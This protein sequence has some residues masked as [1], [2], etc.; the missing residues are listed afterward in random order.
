MTFYHR[1]STGLTKIAQ[2]KLRELGETPKAC[3]IMKKT[4]G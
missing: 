3:A 1:A 4:T 2:Y